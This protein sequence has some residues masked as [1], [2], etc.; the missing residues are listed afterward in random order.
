MGCVPRRFFELEIFSFFGRIVISKRQSSLFN[1]FLL[2]LFF[3]G[4]LRSVVILFLVQIV[5]LHNTGIRNRTKFQKNSDIPLDL[6]NRLVTKFVW[7]SNYCLAKIAIFVHT[8]VF[9]DEKNA[10]MARPKFEF[11]ENFVTSRYLK[12]SKISQQI[13]QDFMRKNLRSLSIRVSMD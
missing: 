7:N 3:F 2:F 12:P 1:F 4:H 8:L 13:T 6:K 9:I 5:C 11:H 10:I